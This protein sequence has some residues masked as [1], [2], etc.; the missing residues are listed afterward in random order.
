MSTQIGQASGAI[1]K[2]FSVEVVASVDQKRFITASYRRYDTS[3]LVRAFEKLG[4]RRLG[5][6]GFD[7]ERP[8]DLA[9]F[10]RGT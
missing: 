5:N 2:S 6:W 1:P 10:Q 7:P 8:S 4:W 3:E 9:L